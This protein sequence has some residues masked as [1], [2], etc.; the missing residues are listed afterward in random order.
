MGVTQKMTLDD[1]EGV[2]VSEGTQKDDDVIYEQP[3]IL[4]EILSILKKITENIYVSIGKTIL[5][6]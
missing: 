4:G 1:R 2:G 5:N 6:G 3:L